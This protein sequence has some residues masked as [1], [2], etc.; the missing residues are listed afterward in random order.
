MSHADYEVSVGMK[1][2]SRIVGSCVDKMSAYAS[3]Y[4]AAGEFGEELSSRLKEQLFP[5]EF[6]GGMSG[7]PAYDTLIALQSFY[8]FIGHVQG[9]LVTLSPASQATWDR[10]F[11]EAVDFVTEQ[12]ERIT[13]WTKQQMGSR[14]S[15][16]LLV[17]CKEAARLKNVFKKEAA[18]KEL[19]GE[20]S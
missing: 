11:V 8:L 12:L 4:R 9:H 18:Q 20:S 13:S 14:A 3:K 10:G 7:S 5:N 19:P 15:Q 6:I 2:M 16:T 1:V 17:P